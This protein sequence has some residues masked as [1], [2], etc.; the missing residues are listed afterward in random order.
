MEEVEM[1]KQQ[2]DFYIVQDAELLIDANKNTDFLLGK[3]TF[4]MIINTL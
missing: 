1:R 3:Y 2:D 4:L